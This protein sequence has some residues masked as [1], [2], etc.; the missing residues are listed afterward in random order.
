MLRF[1]DSGLYFVQD[2]NTFINP[3]LQLGS[4]SGADEKVP[5]PAG[6]KSTDPTGSR[7]SF[8]VEI[9]LNRLFWSPQPRSRSDLLASALCRFRF[10]R[11]TTTRYPDLRRAVSVSASFGTDQWERRIGWPCSAAPMGFQIW[12]QKIA[13]DN[14]NVLLPKSLIYQNKDI[15]PEEKS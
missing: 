11:R 12:N 6:Q 3:L 2:K 10:R 7:S 4:A 8:L 5:D 13:N 14:V 9:P 1:V 15:T